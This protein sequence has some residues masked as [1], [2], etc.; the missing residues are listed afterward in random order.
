VRGQ[1][2]TG[3]YLLSHLIAFC[4][5][6]AIITSLYL[7]T[8]NDL[9]CDCKLTWIWG[10]RNETKNTKL[11]DALEELICFLE[12]SN[13]TQKINNGGLGKNQSPEIASKFF[14]MHT[15][16]ISFSAINRSFASKMC[17]IYV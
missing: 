10:L 9:T 2:Y 5:K 12:S 15:Y 16:I 8:E 7:L 14:F 11:R 6:T 13:A 4:Y 1:L 17:K 3:L